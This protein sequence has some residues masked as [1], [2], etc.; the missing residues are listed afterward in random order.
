MGMRRESKFV[1]SGGGWAL[2]LFNGRHGQGESARSSSFESM[3]QG[4]FVEWAAQLT[5]MPHVY[6]RH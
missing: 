4:M 2:M 6:V 3:D 5:R 1:R